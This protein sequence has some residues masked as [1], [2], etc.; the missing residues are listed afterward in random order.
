MSLAI[1][2][3][4]VTEVLL[5]D[6]WHPVAGR[7]FYLDSYEFKWDAEFV[8]SGGQ[9]DHVPSTGFSFETDGGQ[10]ISG[11]LTAVLAIKH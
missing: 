10:R 8:L 11:P 7:T 5:S 4:D 9:C 2:L 3:D 6:G 1:D